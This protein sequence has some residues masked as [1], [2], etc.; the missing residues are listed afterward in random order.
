MDI[1]HFI[2]IGKENAI[3]REELQRKT[4]RSDR[5]N[6]QQI[7]NARSRGVRII[8]SSGYKGYYIARD[9]KEWVEFLAEHR[10]RANTDMNLYLKG[11]TLLNREIPAD[12][13]I[14]HVREHTR[15]LGPKEIRGQTK[16]EEG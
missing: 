9:D 16:F 13:I 2:P 6:R 14:V 4:G 7:E 1:T 5:V 8:S 12:Q 3:S 10:R 15:V 11:M